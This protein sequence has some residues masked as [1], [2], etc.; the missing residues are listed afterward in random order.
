[1]L[2]RK[3]KTIDPRYD[4]ELN[5][6]IFH[7]KHMRYSQVQKLCRKWGLAG[8]I[9][10]FSGALMISL[11]PEGNMFLFW[12]GIIVLA[13]AFLSLCR[14][15]MLLLELLIQPKPGDLRAYCEKNN[16]D[17]NFGQDKASKATDPPSKKT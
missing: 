1:M 12:T 15:G 7:R 11:R 5:I 14:W 8:L 17:V 6:G 2:M 10:A 4:H 13:A 3:R 16:Y 9:L